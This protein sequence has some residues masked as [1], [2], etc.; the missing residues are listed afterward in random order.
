MITLDNKIGIV[1]VLLL[2][3]DVYLE[4]MTWKELQKVNT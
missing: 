2:L 1:I 3:A 4:Y